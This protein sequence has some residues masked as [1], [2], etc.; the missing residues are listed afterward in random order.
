MNQ[1]RNLI[2]AIVAGAIGGALIVSLV[3]TISPLPVT[4]TSSLSLM[5]TPTPLFPQEALVTGVVE[6]A[7]PGVIS[8]VV[9]KDVPI[10]EEY[11]R[12]G[13]PF[14]DFFGGGSFFSPLPVPQRRERGTERREV[15]GGSGFIVSKDGYAVT[16]RHVVDD[17]AADYTAFTS[18]GE[19]H[20]VEVVAKDSVLDIAILKL[21]GRG[22][23]PFLTLGNSGQIKV[24]QTAIAIGNALGEF[25][26]TVSVGVVS[27]LYRSIVAGD[28]LGEVEA[29]DE[30]IQTDA[31]INPGNS[32]GPL[33]NLSGQVIGV[34]VAMARGSENIG[35]ALP[36]D[37]VKSVIESVRTT[38]KIVRPY[39]GVRYVKVTPA[40]KEKN[41]LP[42]DYGVLVAR[43]EAMDDL[44]VIPGSPADK[45]GIVENDIILEI[46]GKKLDDK[47][48]LA[49]I[50]RAKTV[51][52]TVTLTILHRGERK[53]VKIKLD[54]APE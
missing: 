45:A 41:K 46:D 37:A 23:Y 13:D 35:F 47:N 27:G 39:L 17:A 16:N 1:I 22:E 19:K 36:I 32:G 40:L 26:N 11:F 28:G 14:S 15:G 2:M 3:F 43:G 9:T 44:A 38:G 33:L 8:I 21:K 7:N 34:N 25:E 4:E 5:S 50:V 31:A 51:G 18:D 12:G 52:Q 49:S 6:R 53:I 24:G 42:V 54:A 10:I 20:E 30:V 29:L 48:S